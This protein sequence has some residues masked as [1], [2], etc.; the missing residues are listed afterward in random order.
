MV[1]STSPP[2]ALASMLPG[3]SFL[4]LFWPSS[5]KHV[6]RDPTGAH[7][8]LVLSVRVVDALGPL[9]QCQQGDR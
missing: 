5:D 2:A 7:L 1:S 3:L 6:T 8:R 4:L 9:A